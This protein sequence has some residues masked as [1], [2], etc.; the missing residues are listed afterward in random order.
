[1]LLV[2]RYNRTMVLHIFWSYQGVLLKVSQQRLIQHQHGARLNTGPHGAWTDSSEP[3]RH[4]LGFVY[5]FQA[6]Q[7][8]RGIQGSSAVGFQ[9]RRG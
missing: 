5:D 3:A 1:M 2:A 7:D 8:R 4:S 6:S 9:C